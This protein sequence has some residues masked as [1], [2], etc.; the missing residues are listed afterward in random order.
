MTYSEDQY[1]DLTKW[2][3][4]NYPKEALFFSEITKNVNDILQHFSS[5]TIGVNEEKQL[6]FKIAK[7]A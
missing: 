4:K 3:V 2:L 6:K 1:K 5:S 7:K